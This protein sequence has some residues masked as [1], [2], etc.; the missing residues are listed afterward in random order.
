MDS[1]MAGLIL[2]QFCYIET[3]SFF[4]CFTIHLY[5]NMEDEPL[6]E[7]F[8]EFGGT[9]QERTKFD[10]IQYD[11]REEQINGMVFLLPE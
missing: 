5:P 4:P 7:Y 1:I 2:M 3:D 8:G 6:F 9:L 11:L 10:I